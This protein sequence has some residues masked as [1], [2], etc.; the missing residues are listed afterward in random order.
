MSRRVDLWNDWHTHVCTCGVEWQCSKPE[1]RNDEDCT[2]C[3]MQRQDDHFRARGDSAE[4]L[5]IP[6]VQ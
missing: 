4:Q 1:C 5:E 3:E 2:A 6:R